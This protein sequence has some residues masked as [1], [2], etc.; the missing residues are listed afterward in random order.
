M[1]ISS[2]NVI[3]VPAHDIVVRA[4]ELKEENRLD[5]SHEC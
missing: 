4:H 1:C 2:S 3:L 5:Y